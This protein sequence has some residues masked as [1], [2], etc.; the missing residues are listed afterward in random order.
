LSQ[1]RAARRLLVDVSTIARWSGPPVGIMRAAYE[2]AMRAPAACDG[3]LCFWD[4]RTGGFRALDPTWGKLVC[5]WHAVIDANGLDVIIDRRGIRKFLPSRQPIVTALERLRL[6]TG[7]RTLAMLA[8]RLQR[9]VLAPRGHHFPLYDGRGG[10]LA[11]VP[12]DMALGE[13][14]RLGPADTVL[15]AGTDWYHTDPEAIAALKQR[16]GFRLTVV[17]YDLIPVLFP[18][19]FPAADLALFRRY[20]AAILPVVDLVICNSRVI[21]ADLHDA[22]ATFG[23]RIPRTAVA[24]LGF[25]LPATKATPVTQVTPTTQATL[26]TWATPATWAAPAVLPGGLAAGRYALFVSTIEPRKGHALLLDAWESLLARGIP[27]QHGF[28]LVF[29][30]RA[31]WHVD[32]VLQRIETV[33]R[34]G[35]LLHL[36]GI[37]DA[38]LD[39][40]YR[41]AAFCLY[42]SRYEG[43]GLPIIEAFARGKAVIASSGGAVPE[44]A[45]DLAPCLDPT[46]AAAWAQLVGDWIEQPALPA[47]H[48]ARIRAGFSHPDWAAAAAHILALAAQ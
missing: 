5:D 30:G 36:Q 19:F 18:D 35:T 26:T 11:C 13:E 16:L 10:R 33:S 7:S 8:D 39:A 4:R 25:D 2:L 28:R 46:D 43:F 9:V 47:D 31:G 15:L 3:D 14:I 44:T 12:S 24:P 40:L 42:P 34:G 32:A 38:E 48:E 6:T 20:W 21:E 1:D 23:A 27:Q 22:A 37:R 17:C 41:H 29:V 45:G